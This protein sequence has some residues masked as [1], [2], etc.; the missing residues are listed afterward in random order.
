LT[1]YDTNGYPA[2]VSDF[3][4]NKTAYVHN[5]KGQLLTKVE[6]YGTP[7]ARTYTYEWWGADKN[8]YLK[9]I[10][11][12]GLVRVS[13]DYSGARVT[14]IT[15]TNL[16]TYGV[17]NQSRTT[18]YSTQGTC[19]PGYCLIGVISAVT[20]DGPLS[21]TGDALTSNFD[22]SGN[23][24]SSVNGLGQQTTYS[25]HNGLGQPGRVTGVNGSITDYTYDARGRK[26]SETKIISG[27]SYTTS[28]TYDARGRIVS[29]TQPDGVITKASYD[30][31]DRVGTIS[32][33][34][35]YE[36]GNIDTF[37]ETVTDKL[38]YS[39]NANSNVTQQLNQSNYQGKI[40]DDT[41]G[42][43]RPIPF[44]STVTQRQ[45]F[46]DYDE[47]GRPRAD[48]GNNGQNTRYT[49]DGNGN[50]TSI[51][52]GLNRVTSF[53][54]DSL[55]RLITATNA[56]NGVTRYE[57]DKAD[58]VTKVTD[59]RGLITASA[60]DGFGRMWAE[61]S[62][63]TGTTTY[64]YHADGK[65]ATVTRQNG[66]STTYGYDQAGRVTSVTAG[67]QSTTY[68]YDWC[69]NGVSM[70]CNAN[71]PDSI[72]H[73]GYT[74][75][76]QVAV[77]RELTT[78]NG[79]QSDYWTY[80]YYDGLGRTK[81]VTYPDGSAVGYGYA[82]GVLKA[83]TLNVGGNVTNLVTGAEYRAFGPAT[84]WSYGNG[85]FRYHAY[86]EGYAPGD[87]R[88]TSVKTMNGVTALQDLRMQYRSTDSVSKITNVVSPN[89]TQDFTYDA[90]E[91]LTG[92]AAPAINQT[93]QYDA[94]GNKVQHNWT[95]NES[96]TVEPASNRVVAMTSHGYTN[97]VVGNRRTH[98]WSGSTATYG[99]NS[100]NQMTSVS[101]NSALVAAEPNN[102]TINLPAGTSNYQ[103]NAYG[104]RVW[105]SAPSVGSYRY[106]YGLG[107]RLMAEYKDGS[108]WTNYLWFQDQLI[109]LTR[110][111]Q[112]YFIHVDQLGRP[113]IVTNSGKAVVWRAEN[114]PYD[115]KVTLDSIG[116]LDVGL[117]GQYYDRESNLWYN[118][119][120]Y[121]DARLGRYT[122]SDPI[123]L[124]GGTN[125]YAYVGADPVNL[126]DPLG[127]AAAEGV[128]ADCLKQIF[129]QSVAGVNVRN[130][131]FVDNEWITTRKN[132]I[133]LPPDYSSTEFF[134]NPHLVL[135]E[136][137]HVLKQWNTGDMTRRSYAAEFLRNGAE[138]G[139]KYEDAAD[140]FADANIAAMQNCLQGAMSCTP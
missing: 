11:V 45:A 82:D 119:N 29:T 122:Q 124:M 55:G 59:P 53:T 7:E 40:M 22:T 99:Y 47:L 67:G 130:K 46:V 68:G 133:R 104:E 57:Y 114:Y 93:F 1:E 39:Y 61:S 85:L 9:S 108:G 96:V 117:P 43:P 78:A 41:S 15:T 111:G 128:M 23:L 14:S 98:S 17:A 94:N 121:Y 81:A 136:Y 77:R 70:L 90:L 4:D 79:V 75:E 71:S 101:R 37:D 109:G 112:T 87:Q 134:S 92:V 125:T 135:H 118:I 116:G 89:L 13:Y 91:R 84:S 105:K 8:N 28:F 131:Q 51:T 38:V 65:L 64:A 5:A 36:D 19:F 137:Y 103:Y 35:P 10:T 138:K 63:D 24:I 56:L 33:T 32:R 83:M 140:A 73:Y 42:R 20:E 44:S 6:G 52:D 113:E 106:V 54:Y 48:R 132:S 100:A 66:V 27:V 139:N 86:D 129:G 18:T 127:L 126:V 95:W 120:R 12:G 34:R 115:R 123:G 88:P 80:F 74:P 31:Q 49:Y 2:M 25:N 110:S 69:G 62:P 107:N 21:G 16:S 3:N 60:Y 102:T 72:I 50:I 26:L 58:R 30:V 76:G 97:D